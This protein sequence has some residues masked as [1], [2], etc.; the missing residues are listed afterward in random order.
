MRFALDT[1]FNCEDNK[2]I[3]LISI[4]L[5]SEDGQEYYA[6]STEFDMSK[7]S[8]WLHENVLL[9]LPKIDSGLKVVT[10]GGCRLPNA[11]RK[12]KPRDQIARDIRDLLNSQVDKAQ[13]WTYFGGYDFV[14]FCQLFGGF[15]SL[16]TNSPQYTM[17]L[18]QRMTDLG[19]KKD[20]L[21]SQKTGLHDALEDARWTM[22]CL[23]FLDKKHP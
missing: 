17:D 22:E 10:T 23:K 20:Q 5:V 18:R 19:I 11:N 16:P 14:A 6:V 13:I 21:P 4:A 9:Q 3:D 15:F 1:E 12:W 7:C 2:T 8:D